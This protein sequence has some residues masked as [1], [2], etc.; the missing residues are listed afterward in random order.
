MLAAAEKK[1][2]VLE[3]TPMQIKKSVTGTG[4]AEKNQII[5]EAFSEVEEEGRARFSK[6][7]K[8]S[9]VSDKT[10]KRY[11]EDSVFFEFDGHDVIHSSF[12]A[13]EG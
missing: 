4:A 1:L 8:A 2:P 10:L 13:N 3:F 9:E 5:E 11:I 7:V 6:M 12:W